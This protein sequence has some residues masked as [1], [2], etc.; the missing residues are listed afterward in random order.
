MGYVPGFSTDLFL[1]YA[2]KDDSDAARAGGP[3]SASWIGAFENA[4]TL[5]LGKRLGVPAAVWRDDKK[6][7]GGDHFPT[8]IE[9]AVRAAA[10]FMPVVS[11]HY[12]QSEYCG[13]ER[14]AFLKGFDERDM[15]EARRL[16]SLSQRFV[17]LIRLPLDQDEHLEFAAGVQSIFL[18]QKDERGNAFELAPGPGA[19]ADKVIDAAMTLAGILRK[20]RRE[21]EKVYLA[22]PAE[23]VRA[24][25]TET[26]DE[27]VSQGYNVE[28]DGR[29]DEMYGD[30]WIERRLKGA[31]L[32]VHLLGGEF[33][34][35]A[36][37]QIRLA[38]AGGYRLLFWL[39][40][41]T[42]DT[43]DERQKQLLENVAA[44]RIDDVTS[45]PE[46][47][48]NLGRCSIIDLRKEILARLS[49][50]T[51]LP[52]V[53]A[54]AAGAASI[55]LCCGP[56]DI[57][58]GQRLGDAIRQ[59]VEAAVWLPPADPAQRM[60]HHRHLLGQ[61]NAVLLYR[62]AA[63][64]DWLRQSLQDITLGRGRSPWKARALVTPDPEPWR[65][66]PVTIIPR[67]PQFSVDDLEPF[68]ST[69]RK[70]G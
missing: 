45:F 43:S 28:P 59:K 21:R 19:F 2:H 54:D 44:G 70:A 34:E 13:L 58:S 68:L 60:E 26:R 64:N 51:A 23:D 39:S 62:E 4:L 15:R 37:R 12:I 3:A 5:E 42:R 38:A 65:S 18:F 69:L 31:K 66:Y 40:P 25:R 32:S 7:R 6:L 17:P 16:M 24:S 14:D 55:Y 1:S 22:W 8:E 10:V 35:G 53:K 57:T 27:L 11:P 47:W 56:E 30:A 9:T 67:R 63:S 20:L 29:P 36:E 46:G 41:Q 61:C 33:D 49:P 52:D 48:A 50:R